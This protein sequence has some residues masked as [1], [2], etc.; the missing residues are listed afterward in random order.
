MTDERLTRL[1]CWKTMPICRR[2]LRISVEEAAVM[3]WS[4]Q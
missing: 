4:F 1:N 2:I 3:S